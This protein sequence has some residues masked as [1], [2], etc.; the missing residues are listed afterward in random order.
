M[1]AIFAYRVVVLSRLRLLSLRMSGAYV[2]WIRILRGF[3]TGATTGRGEI[4]L[5]CGRT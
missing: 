4:E 5:E 3:R 2:Q 1:L